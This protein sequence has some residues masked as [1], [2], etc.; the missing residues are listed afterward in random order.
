MEPLFTQCYQIDNKSRKVI[1][2]LIFWIL[3]KMEPFSGLYSP[4]DQYQ[5]HKIKHKM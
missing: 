3:N 2:K 5:V 1:G 4:Q